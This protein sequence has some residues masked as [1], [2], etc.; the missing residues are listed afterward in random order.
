[1]TDDTATRLARMETIEQAK[2]LMFAYAEAV[3]RRDA[4]ALGRIFAD[5]AVM[6]SASGERVGHD[7]VMGYYVA[8][9]SSAPV[10]G[11]H[12]LTNQ[13][14]VSAGA[15]AA[16]LTAYFLYT[17]A[18]DEVSIIGWGTYTDSMRRDAGGVL[19]VARKHIDIEFRGP[20]HDGWAAA[21]QQL[22]GRRS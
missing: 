12:F 6:A 10:S 8:H 15:D 14:V 1:M 18:I 5:D 9:F 17:T 19:R 20:L 2:D 16:E 7:A 3:D 22:A 11:R 13:R 21:L 4:Q